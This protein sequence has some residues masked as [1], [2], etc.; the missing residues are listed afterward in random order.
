MGH[1]FIKKP[2]IAILLLVMLVP[3]SCNKSDKV[4]DEYYDNSTPIFEVWRKPSDAKTL[5]SRCV[6]H[7]ILLDTVL[8]TSPN[9]QK[10]TSLLGGN[11]YN[12]MDEIILGST[13]MESN[14]LW[15]FIFRGRRLESGRRFTSY[16]EKTF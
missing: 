1:Y 15:K 3:A 11:Q 10:Y 16:L 14:G 4:T 13:F 5:L 9:G 8:I 2:S 6:T 12:V 7:D